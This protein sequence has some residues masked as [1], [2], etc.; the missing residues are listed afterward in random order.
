[1]RSWDDVNR[2]KGQIRNTWIYFEDIGIERSRFV[3]RGRGSLP[4][5][6][7]P[8]CVNVESEGKGEE[9]RRRHEAI[10]ITAYPQ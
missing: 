3:P 6:F 7:V 9:N 8:R 10:A 2:Q 4:P 1:M 5:Y